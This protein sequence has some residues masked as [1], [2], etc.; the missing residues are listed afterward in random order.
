M[1]SGLL[2]MPGPAVCRTVAHRKRL[3]I[4]IYVGSHAERSRMYNERCGGS[5]RLVNTW[6][7]IWYKQH[8]GG[9]KKQCS[10][11]IGCGCGCGCMDGKEILEK[12]E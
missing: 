3:I 5:R 8:K 2:I 9:Q 4:N 6:I 7:T 11:D 10:C 1:G 12:A